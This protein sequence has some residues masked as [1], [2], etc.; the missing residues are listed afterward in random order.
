[1]F[2]NDRDSCY[3]T[4]SSLDYSV[5]KTVEQEL[6][7]LNQSD[8]SP[9][10]EHYLENLKRRFFGIGIGIGSFPIEMDAAITRSI[11]DGINTNRYECYVSYPNRTVWYV[12]A[13]Y[14]D[15]EITY[16]YYSD[17]TRLS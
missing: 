16:V 13:I 7:Q 6:N 15:G 10:V 4:I 8:N 14:E 1:M 2:V 9:N 12:S 17:N 5:I 3:I 11:K